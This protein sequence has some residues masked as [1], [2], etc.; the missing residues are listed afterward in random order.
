MIVP[1]DALLIEQV[2][3]NLLENAVM[4]AKGLDRL[5]LCVSRQKERAVFE[6]RD[7]GCGIPAEKFPKLFDT[8]FEPDKTVAD[9]KKRNAGIGLAVCATIVRAH[10][11][12][13]HAENPPEGGAVFRFLLNISGEQ[14]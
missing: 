7:N 5:S 8:Y 4:H 2:L 10:G 6:V 13:I 14:P 11:G 1:M 12:E 3:V 9:G